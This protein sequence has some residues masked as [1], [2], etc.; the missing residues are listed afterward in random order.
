[1]LVEDLQDIFADL[2]EFTLDLLSVALDHGNLC[3]VALGFLFLLNGGDDSPRC[4]TG[5]N[6]VLVRN[7][8]QIAFLNGEFL[9]RRG[10]TLHVLNHFWENEAVL[11]PNSERR[12]TPLTFIT[13]GL[14]SE[15]GEVDRIFA[16]L[17]HLELD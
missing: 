13:L 14:L 1:M 3:F 15:L 7:R 6:D 4:A 5:S 9:V 8:K 10:D 2:G 16:G 11:M 12:G 17:R